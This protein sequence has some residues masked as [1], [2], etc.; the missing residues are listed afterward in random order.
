LLAY[1]G[2][3][4][5]TY[6]ANDGSLNSNTATVGLIVNDG[7][8]SF[9]FLHDPNSALNWTVNLG[10]NPETASN[11]KAGSQVLSGVNNVIA[12][13][14]NNTIIGNS[15][16]DVLIGGAGNDTI[17]GGTGAD[18]IAAGGGTNVLSGGGGNNTF[19]F[20]PDPSPTPLRTSA[21]Q[22]ICWT[23]RASPASRRKI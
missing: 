15:H 14:G 2:P 17:K 22:A 5:F 20:T 11:S 23:S 8:N 1:V 7:P 19:V 21:P 3:D 6:E 10:G 13:S 4:S 16:G 18:V 12:G 9:D